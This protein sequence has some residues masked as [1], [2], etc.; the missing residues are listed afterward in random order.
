MDW[1]KET[2][3]NVSTLLNLDFGRITM[4]LAVPKNWEEVNS[5]SD[6]LNLFWGQGKN[7]RLSTEYLNTAV[8][9]VKANHTYKKKYKE[10][11]PLVITPWWKR[12]ANAR[13]SI[14]LSFG[15]TEAKPPENA[16]AIIEVV[17]TG[18]TLDQN[19]LKI[20]ETITESTAVLIA[21]REALLDLAKREKIFDIVTLLK[22]V[23]EARKKLHIFVNVKK[24]N[25]DKL[26]QGLPALKS[27][28]ISPLLGEEWY[29]VNTVI[30]RKDF[31]EILPTLR[32]LTQG[33]VVHVPRQI[34]S[35][36]EI[37]KVE[38]N[39]SKSED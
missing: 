11:E 36:E 39:D 1:V 10:T 30:N 25:L 22:G 18:T 7:I 38:K 16:E 28:T 12:G 32:K 17:E 29:A 8:Q 34:L 31:L 13:V 3:V 33:L 14:F 24:T 19:N 2:G 4:V 37:F 20:I 26:V 9:Y 15:A 27:P 21:N 35:L 5:L 6:L 23:V